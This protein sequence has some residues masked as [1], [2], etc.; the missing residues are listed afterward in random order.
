MAQRVDVQYIDYNA[1]DIATRRVL[2]GVFPY[3]RPLPVAKKRKALRICIDPVAIFGIVVATCMLI[4]MGAGISR[5]CAEQEKCAVME[6]YVQRL[7]IQNDQ[8][9]AEYAASCDL[10]AIEKTALA[11]GMIPVQEAARTTITV[12]SVQTREAESFWNRMGTFLTGL[13]A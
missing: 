3:F 8:L 4:M 11:L 13:F 9:K 7:E 2:P 1:R 6:D 5:L 10:E 12:E